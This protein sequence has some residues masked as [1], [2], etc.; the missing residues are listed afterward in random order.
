VGGVLLGGRLWG[1]QSPCLWH[2]LVKVTLL[3]L[4]CIHIETYDVGNVLLKLPGSHFS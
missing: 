3:V 4:L 2:R 1:F